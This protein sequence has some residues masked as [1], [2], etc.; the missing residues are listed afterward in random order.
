MMGIRSLKVEDEFKCERTNFKVE[1]DFLSQR[2]NV[3]GDMTKFKNQ[4]TM[5]KV[6]GQRLKAEDEIHRWEDKV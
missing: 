4:R 5:G 6:R 3:K 2:T 1:D